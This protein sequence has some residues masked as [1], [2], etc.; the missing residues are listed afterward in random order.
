MVRWTTSPGSISRAGQRA[1]LVAQLEDEPLGAL[2][3]DAGDLRQR[4]NVASAERATHGHRAVHGEQG[5]REAGTDAGHGLDRLED[6]LLV[7]GREAVESERVLADDEARLE[8]GGLA[9]PH[10]RGGRRRRVD[11]HAHA[12]DAEDDGV[13]AGLE[14]GSGQ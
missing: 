13:E 11:E 9:D 7:L 1:E 10:G 5:Q 4:R 8:L 6:V 14:D 12:S 3:A 2:L